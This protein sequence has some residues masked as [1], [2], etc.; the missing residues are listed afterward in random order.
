[1]GLIREKIERAI[2]WW[3]HS[4][5]G[6]VLE[7]Y[8]NH[9]G[10]ILAGGLAFG[11]LFAF[12]A[13]I[14]TLFSAFG[15]F[16]SNN[17]A[18]R[19]TLI[20]AL[21]RI[22]PG[23]ISSSGSGIISQ[24]TLNGIATTFTITGVI[25]F[26]TFFWKII[27]WLGSLR[28]AVQTVVEK[29]DEDVNAVKSKGLDAA[30]VLLVAVLF[31]LTGVATG[32]SGGAMRMILNVLGISSDFW[33]F[34][35]LIDV[36][37]LAVTFVLN[38]C[39]LLVLLI[40]VSQIHAR[41]PVI[42]TSVVG[43]IALSIIQMLGARLITGASSN[44]LLAPFA[45]II[46][47]LLWF[48]LIAQVLMYA[49]ALLGELLLTVDAKTTSTIDRSGGIQIADRGGDTAHGPSAESVAIASGKADV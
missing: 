25:T 29:Q 21:G 35:A 38:V 13:G 6:R 26:V 24:S 30:A 42:I 14:W 22:V 1:M 10:S 3:K 39:L 32:I 16:F 20:E 28:S 4:L 23:L 12:F 2:D 46:G 40:M 49:A 27:S 5:L 11:L 17:T 41:R 8:G 9:N 7:R 47:V 31:V 33:G 34:S 48:N 45:A 15:L 19:D 37:G 43:A 18:F 36:A 44:P